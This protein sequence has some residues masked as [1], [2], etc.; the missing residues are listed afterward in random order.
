MGGLSQQFNHYADTKA[1]VPLPIRHQQY[2]LLTV[3]HRKGRAIGVIL[4][5]LVD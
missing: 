4:L 1:L 2:E 5:S 3:A